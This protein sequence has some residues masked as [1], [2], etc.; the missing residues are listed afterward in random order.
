MIIEIKK[1]RS[2]AGSSRRGLSYV[3]FRVENDSRSLVCEYATFH[4]HRLVNELEQFAHVEDVALI[5]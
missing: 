2:L 1:E 3:Q 4:E 5:I